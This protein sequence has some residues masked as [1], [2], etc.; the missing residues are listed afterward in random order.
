MSLGKLF[1]QIHPRDKAHRERFR[2][3]NFLSH[4]MWLK[5]FYFPHNLLPVNI[6]G[7]KQDYS[8]VIMIDCSRVKDEKLGFSHVV[9][10]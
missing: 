9:L 3:F 10:S 1:L 8:A 2:L 5:V 7:E 6:G 4:E